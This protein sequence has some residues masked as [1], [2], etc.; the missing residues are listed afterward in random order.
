MPDFT[1]PPQLRV[2]TAADADAIAALHTASWRSAYRDAL[3]EAY[4]QGPI[5]QERLVFWRDRYSHAGPGL[6][7]VVAEDAKGSLVGFLCALL[8]HDRDWGN[9]IHNLHVDPD[10]KQQ[11][12]GRMM[13]RAAA[14]HFVYALPRR[15][16]YLFVLQ[17]NI[18]AQ[19]F[20]NR[21]GGDP[22]EELVATQPDGTSARAIRYAWP[23]VAA[24]AEG[25]A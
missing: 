5:E 9:Y 19:A 24:F 12:I 10:A 16:V 4:L 8:D 6:W 15:P 25:V 20:Y 23:S 14:D 2:A 22:V 3:S 1:T 18:A 21:L 13:M 17:S 11:G 7:T